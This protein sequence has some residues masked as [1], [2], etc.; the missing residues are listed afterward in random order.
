LVGT[1]RDVSVVTVSVAHTSTSTTIAIRE[2][3]VVTHPNIAIEDLVVTIG[4]INVVLFVKE[5]AQLSGIDN[6]TGNERQGRPARCSTASS[7]I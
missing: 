3:R 4:R 1:I 6:T 5:E 7:E 2:G